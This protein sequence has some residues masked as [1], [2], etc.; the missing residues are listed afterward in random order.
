MKKKL[1]VSL[2]VFSMALGLAACGNSN[3]GESTSGSQDAASADNTESSG[4][5]STNNAGNTESSEDGKSLEVW[6]RNSYYDEVTEAAKNFTATT[7]IAVNVSEP[8]DMS[9]DLALALS[10]GNVPD[11]VSIDCVLVPYY[12]SIGALKD[13]TE[14]FA[15]SDFK[16][17]FSGGLLDLSSYE[18][19][20]YAVPFAPDV[21]V[22][23]YNKDI[24]EANGLDPENPP[25]TWDELIAA[26]QACTNDDVYGYMFS[27]SDAGGMMFTFCPYI[28]CNG[29]EFTSEDGKESLLNQPEAVEALQFITDMI[30][31]YNVTPQSITSYDW[32]ATEDAFK[33]QKAAMIVQ[34]SSAVGTIVNDGYDFNAGCALIPS[35]DGNKYSSFSG[36]DSIA[37]LADTDM[38]DEAWQFV[39][40]CLSK[41]VQVDQ[42]AAYGNIPARS[43]M[44]ENDIFGSHEEYDILRQALE[45]GEAPYSL[46][47]NEMYTPWIDAV[48][49]ALNQEKTPEEAFSDAK[50]EIDALLS[51]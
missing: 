12:S 8:S 40:Y 29:G 36:G 44:F 33:A 31:E 49:Y 42:L 30:Y 43:D 34:G 1:L 27:A 51:E 24:F 3:K 32:T 39:Q 37:I 13:I 14:E 6:V 28:W 11:I 2:L 25:K 7:G 19:K 17:T 10:S 45:V 22:L 15:A 9:D 20:Q 48:Q 26:A 5:D 4:A 46:K 16:D 21:S 47:Y 35:P 50:E 38:P 23:L 41:E 18:G